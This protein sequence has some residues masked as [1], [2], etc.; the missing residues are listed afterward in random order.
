MFEKLIEMN[1]N[2]FLVIDENNKIGLIANEQEEKV[3]DYIFHKMNEIELIEEKINELKKKYSFIKILDKTRKIFNFCLLALSVTFSVLLISEFNS[4]FKA[5][6][7]GLITFIGYKS[8]FTLMLG[9]KKGNI[10]RMNLTEVQ[11]ME[12]K[13]N[14][15]NLQREID[16]INS[17]MEIID[18]EEKENIITFETET[19]EKPKVKVISLR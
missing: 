19:L 18:V 3:I 16:E 10:K 15:Y 1:K 14:I 11:I 4:L 8:L 7:Y 2:Q 9:T 17:K 13:E 6:T 12:F 5:F